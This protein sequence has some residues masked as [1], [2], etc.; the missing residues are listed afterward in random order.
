M[1]RSMLSYSTL[2][3]SLWM[4]ALKTA[5]H[6]LNRVPSKSVPKTPYKIWTGRNPTLNYLHVWGCSTEAKLFNPSI[7]K[8]DPKTVSCHFIGYPDK[9]KGFRFYCLDRYIKIVET[10]HTVFLE[11]EV[12]R[13]STVPREIRLEEKWICVPTSMVAEPLFSVPAAAAPMAQGNVV[14]EPV[15]NSPI[16]MAAMP[17]VGSP[18]TEVDEYLVPVFQKPIINHEEQQEPLIQDVSHSEPPRRSQRARRS[19]IPDD[20]EVYVSEEIQMEGDFTS[21]E[22]VMRSA[23]SFKWLDAMEDEMRSMSVNK[24]WDLEEIPKGAKTVG[25][26]WVY[27]TK[28][29]SNGNIERFKARLIA[30]GFTQ[31]EDIDYTK[32]F[33][34]VSCNDSLRIIMALVMHYD[35]KLHQMD[36]KT[37]FLNG[38][39]LE[40]VYMAQPKGFAVK[41]KEHMGCHLR[42]FIYGLK[43]AS[44]QWYLKFNETIRSFAFK[45]NEEDN[46]I[47]AKFRNGK[48]IFLI[49]YVDD[50]LL[51]SSDVSLLLET[52][53]FL[54]SNFD[55][56]DLGETSFILGIEIH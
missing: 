22:E 40:N 12:I 13:E 1:V 44:R 50:I 49:F 7:E 34:S 28:C 35:L 14:A 56:K 52:K 30:K 32:T 46:C 48:L 10:R 47:Y 38:D 29:D 37:T 16:P 45:E 8:L 17:I 2:L 19:A 4:E 55:M 3:I 33:S 25:C 15:A 42:K 43:Q 5:V 36:V 23:Y 51:A 6:I 39:L 18:M 53:R 27:K 20:Y 31:R 9:S 11:D 26:K 54:S 21:F 24:V 41:G